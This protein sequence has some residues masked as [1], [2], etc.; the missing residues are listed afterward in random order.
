MLMMNGKILSPKK[1]ICLFLKLHHLMKYYTYGEIIQL[2]LIYFFFLTVQ[3]I[4]LSG[5]H[6]G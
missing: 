3:I 1:M 4:R 5:Y 2:V 6:Y